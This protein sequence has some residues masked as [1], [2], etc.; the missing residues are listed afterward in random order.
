M[1]IAVSILILLGFVVI[2][3]ALMLDF[4][5]IATA[6]A[7]RSLERSRS[8]GR[9]FT[10]NQTAEESEAKFRFV[11]FIERLVGAGLALAGVAI[12]IGVLISPPS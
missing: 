9:V 6:H 2:G 5:G 12:I 1:K 4:R 3:L 7:R 11:L 8:M 10:P